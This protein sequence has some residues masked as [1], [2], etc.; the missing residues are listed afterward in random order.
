MLSKLSN[1]NGNLPA[2]AE[3]IAELDVQ[4]QKG[5]I[6]KYIEHKLSSLK[7]SKFSNTYTEEILNG[8]LHEFRERAEDNLLWVSLVFRDIQ[9][10]R[11]RYAAKN[12]KNYPPGLSKLYDHKMPRIENVQSE[13]L[14]PC[15]DVLAV[16]SLAYRPLSLSEL[17]ILAC[18]SD[19]TDP[20]M[21]VEKCD[22]FLTIKEETVYLVHKS[23]KDYLMKKFES[24][25]HSAGVI[26]WHTDIYRRSIDALST[27]KQDIYDLGDFGFRSKDTQ[28]PDPDLLAPMRYSCLFGVDHLCDASKPNDKLAD[29]EVVWSFLKDHL[30]HWL[31]SLSL[32][33][34]LPDSVRSI[35]RILQ[36][37][38]ALR[39]QLN[40]N[41][42]RHQLQS[43]ISPQL[44]RF[45]KDIEKFIFSYGSIIDRA[46]LQAYG[47]ALV[48]SPRLSEVKIQQW[49]EKLSFIKDIDGIKD[50]DVHLQTL[51]GH[52]NSVTAIAFSPDGRT[53]A[54]GVI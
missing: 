38:Y 6:E 20:W 53:L 30:L 49:N 5:R 32:L 41:T 52:S 48:F 50:H 21:I 13:H 18:L 19:D 3:V 23:A 34:R 22:S 31:E 54:F 46:P 14:Q 15:K 28:P 8:M 7:S 44:I 29:N 45:L 25:L 16:A 2:N 9:G 43:S 36:E 40:I 10:M 11:G 35:R 4:N 1:P 51:E 27:L 47:S 42:K 17:A 33:G 39:S 26:Q 37:V 12:I 24:K